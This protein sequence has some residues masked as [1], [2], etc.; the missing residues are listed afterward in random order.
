PKKDNRVEDASALKS[1]EKAPLGPQH[2]MT[3]Q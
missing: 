1:D 3:M 2:S